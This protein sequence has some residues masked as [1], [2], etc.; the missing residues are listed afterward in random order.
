VQGGWT[1]EGKPGNSPLIR[2]GLPAR[3]FLGRG[4]FML[5]KPSLAV[6]SKIHFYVFYLL[7]FIQGCYTR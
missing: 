5:G 4:D 2:F 6:S 7:F 1:F 3:V